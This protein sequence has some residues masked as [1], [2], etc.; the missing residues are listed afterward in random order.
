MSFRTLLHQSCNQYA[1][2]YSEIVAAVELSYK[3]KFD[4]VVRKVDELNCIFAEIQA[5]DELL[6][7]LANNKRIEEDSDLWQQRSDLIHK[8]LI[9]H[10]DKLP[11]LLSIA[12]T[13]KA[14]LE[15]VRIGRRGTNGY[16]TGTKNTGKFFNS[17]S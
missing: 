1:S 3:E 13:K 15:K 2:F 10:T 5:T 14:E 9:F 12:A 7:D 11:H 6:Y 17:S 16:H 8:T 4:E